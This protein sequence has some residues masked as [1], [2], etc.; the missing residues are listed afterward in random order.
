[1]ILLATIAAC[2]LSSTRLFAQPSE[3]AV[4]FDVASVKANATQEP[5]AIE[6]TPTR[7]S[8]HNTDLG[9]LIMRA[10]NVAERQFASTGS[11]LP[12][13]TGRYDVE[14][15]ASAPVTRAESELSA[16]VQRI[17]GPGSG[18]GATDQWRGSEF[19]QEECRPTASLLSLTGAACAQSA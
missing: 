3:P 2:I 12:I 4:S 6:I 8:I 1:M 17:Q 16:S 15:K 9:H 13:L 5:A 19:R 18:S 7:L 11:W 10:Y 14:A